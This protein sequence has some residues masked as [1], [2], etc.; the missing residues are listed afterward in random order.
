[1]ANLHIGLVGFQY[2][3]QNTIGHLDKLL[4]EIGEL[5][6][7]GPEGVRPVDGGG[8]L[9]PLALVLLEGGDVVGVDVREA[10]EDD[11]GRGGRGAGGDGGVLDRVS[12]ASDK[13]GDR[14]RECMI[15]E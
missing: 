11:L 5:L 1:M 8:R 15:G 7:V 14:A 9:V 13:E 2:Q 4:G 10:G 3:T 6:L 12:H